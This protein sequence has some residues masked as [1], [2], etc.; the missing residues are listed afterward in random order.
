MCLVASAIESQAL[1]VA[2]I[3][4]LR[5]AR[6]SSLEQGQQYTW[7]SRGP[8]YDGAVGVTLAAPGGA[9]APVPQWTQQSRMLMNGKFA[10]LNLAAAYALLTSF[11]TVCATHSKVALPLLSVGTYVHVVSLVSS[12]KTFVDWHGKTR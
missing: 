7:S 2:S 6:R 3:P 1:Q 4:L 10:L 11:C 12:I 8:T 5:R 9:I